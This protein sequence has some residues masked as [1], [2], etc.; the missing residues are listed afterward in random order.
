MSP[1]GGCTFCSKLKCRSHSCNS[2]HGRLL[3][4]HA[5][6]TGTC[7]GEHDTEKFVLDDSE[8]EPQEPVEACSM[9]AL[10]NAL[11][12]L[13]Q[14]EV[15]NG[16]RLQT[17]QGNCTSMDAFA[18]NTV[19]QSQDAV[20]SNLHAAVALAILTIHSVACSGAVSQ[21]QLLLLSQQHAMGQLQKAC[22]TGLTGHPQSLV[23]VKHRQPAAMCQHLK[24][25]QFP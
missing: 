13:S 2:N 21:L 18:A 4:L 9:W 12:Q 23:K 6:G 3:S 19:T 24:P 1:S 20:N 10:S 14:S 16:P 8:N 11:L 7:P 25:L 22:R 17:V 15:A 5:H